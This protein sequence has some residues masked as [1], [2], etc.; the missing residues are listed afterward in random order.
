MTFLTPTTITIR[1]TSVIA[2]CAISTGL[3]L[4]VVASVLGF[5]LALPLGVMLIG[6]GLFF[7]PAL[8]VA[9]MFGGYYL[10]FLTLERIGIYPYTNLTATYLACQNG[11]TLLSLLF[12]RYRTGNPP[13]MLNSNTGM[14]AIFVGYIFAQYFLFSNTPG[15]TK[16]LG[17][18]V[19]QAIPGFLVGNLLDRQVAIRS[20]RIAFGLVFFLGVYTLFQVDWHIG[21]IRFTGITYWNPLIHPYV[22]SVGAIIIICF[23]F[24]RPTSYQPSRILYLAL[25]VSYLI[26]FFINCILTASRGPL[27]SFAVMVIVMAIY[28]LRKRMLKVQH[29][30]IIILFFVLLIPLWGK[31]GDVFM[32]NLRRIEETLQIVEVVRGKT[33]MVETASSIRE[34]FMMIQEQFSH[35]VKNPILGIGFGNTAVYYSYVHNSFLEVLFETGFIGAVLFI[36]IIYKVGERIFRIWKESSQDSLFVTIAFLW[37]YFAIAG[38]FSLSLFDNLSFWFFTGAILRIE[39]ANCF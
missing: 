35:F 19:I 15:A 17:F 26:V 1:Q 11:L 8:L 13:K 18:L 3:M 34:R 29:A 39:N 25:L 21:G 33:A 36:G 4:L 31:I 16:K 28:F 38:L 27:L 22:L 23:Y 7:F 37:L 2:V 24:L 12:Y 5:R 30:F 9:V 10:Y 32:G 20:F 6:L 14:V